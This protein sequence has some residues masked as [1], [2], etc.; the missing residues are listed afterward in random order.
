M[1]DFVKAFDSI[2]HSFI[3][4]AMGFFGFGGI[5][6]G[7]VTT[8][9]NNRRACID[10]GSG[11]GEY[12]PIARGAPQGDRSS[13]YIFIIC[14]EILILKLECDET[15]NVKGIERGGGEPAT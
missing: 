11:H 9:L 8:L 6:T 12:F 4:K 3:S 13:P 5:L 10:L 1:V 2:E 7:M 15:G 14:I